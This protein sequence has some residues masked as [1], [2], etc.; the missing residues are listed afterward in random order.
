MPRRTWTDAVVTAFRPAEKVYLEAD[1]GLPGHYCRVQPGGSKTFVAMSRDPRGKQRWVTVGPTSLHSLAEARDRAREIIRAVK[2]GQDHAPVTT[3]EGASHEWFKRHVEK[4]ALRSAKRIR[5]RLDT[6]ILPAWG[7]RDFTS[8][9]RLDVAKLLDKIEDER[10]PVAADAALAIITGI[11]N[12][13]GERDDSFVNPCGKKM[14]RSSIR[15]RARTRILGDD[16]L[17]AVWTVAA[18]NGTY[19]ALLRVLLL[20]AQRREKVVAMKWADLKDGVWTIPTDAREKG[21]ARELVLPAAAIEIIESLPRF[22]SNPYVF[23]GRH[24]H[25]NGFSTAKRLFDD[26]L[27]HVEPWTLHDLRRTARSLMSRAGVL[28]HVSERVLGH[29]IEGVEA[30]YD[31]HGYRDEKAHALRALSALIDSIVLPRENVVPI[32]KPH[33]AGAV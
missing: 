23:A 12:W 21:N 30:T 10:G 24:G 32:K 20:T 31:R 13:H 8:I 5:Q 22:A 7:G 16:E 25:L 26:K 11:F 33:H 15:E 18:A 4:K 17:R 14:R 29:V 1:P 19:G 28:P 27:R 3:F 6:Q 9:T 2:A